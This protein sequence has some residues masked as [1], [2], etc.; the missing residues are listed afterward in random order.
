MASFNKVI[1]M[2][3]LTR[4]PELRVPASTGN[5]L[6]NFGLAVNRRYRVGDEQREETTFVDLT[7]FGRQAEVI[8]K[9]CSKG[10]SILVEGR[11]KLDQWESQSGEK[12]SKLNVIVENFQF[13]ARGDSDSS[14]GG[15][16]YE[17]SSPPKRSGGGGAP[18]GSSEDLEEDV[19]F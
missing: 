14:G 1:L 3:N 7:A 18:S 5:P 6:C 15:G 12:R 17:S 8:A 9:Y 16:S 13:G 11:L 4:D 2:G 10:S 19:P